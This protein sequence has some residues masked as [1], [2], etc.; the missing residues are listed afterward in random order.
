MSASLQILCQD[1]RL[2]YMRQHTRMDR[3]AL[4]DYAATG[5]P[6]GNIQLMVSQI[7][8]ALVRDRQATP[9]GPGVPREAQDT[10]QTSDRGRTHL[11]LP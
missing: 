4:A 5:L 1:N 6:A 2:L 3:F 9:A 10:L 8:R 7:S 11:T